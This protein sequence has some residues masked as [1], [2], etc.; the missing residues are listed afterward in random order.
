MPGLPTRGGDGGSSH[1]CASVVGA[2]PERGAYILPI[3]ITKVI[4]PGGYA[5]EPARG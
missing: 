1:V 2:G 3:H 4:E 5:P